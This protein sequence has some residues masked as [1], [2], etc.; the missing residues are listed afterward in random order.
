VT[1]AESKEAL[2]EEDEEKGKGAEEEVATATREE[3]R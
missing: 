2:K 3:V 1:G